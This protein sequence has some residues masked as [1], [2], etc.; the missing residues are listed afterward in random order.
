[1]WIGTMTEQST[2]SECQTSGNQQTGLTVRH[3]NNYQI[4]NFDRPPFHGGYGRRAKRRRL[5]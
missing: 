3:D 4:T 2:C 5:W 1:M